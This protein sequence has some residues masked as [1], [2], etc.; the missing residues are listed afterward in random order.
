VVSS[1]S[2]APSL[3]LASLAWL[4]L[5]VFFFAEGPQDEDIIGKVMLKIFPA[6]GPLDEDII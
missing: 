2:F 1:P 6:K 4:L 3:G 5:G